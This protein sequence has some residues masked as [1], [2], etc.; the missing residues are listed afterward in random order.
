VVGRGQPLG[1]F[2]FVSFAWSWAV[3]FPLALASRGLFPALPPV[4]HLLIAFGPL[5]GGVAASARHDGGWPAARAFLGR[6]WKGGRGR[7][8]AAGAL[9]P[10]ALFLAGGALAVS[11]RASRAV[12]E[13]GGS[14]W[15]GPSAVVA[16]AAYTLTFGIGEETGWRGFLLPRLAARHGPVG[17]TLRLFAV[18]AGWHLPLLLDRGA[19][20]AGGAFGF[21]QFFA[22]LFAGAFVQTW[23]ASRASPSIW[24]CA[25][26]HGTI[27]GCAAF[28]DDAL[29]G[30][31]VAAFLC[32]GAI[33]LL[34]RAPQALAP[35]QPRPSGMGEG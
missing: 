27:N 35:L 34:L 10:V 18:W 24:P 11:L 30:G 5:L 14:T 7:W 13:G 8:L 19:I 20:G 29:V 28:V 16:S 23:L 26:L 33:V 25:I 12:P 4:L 22:G 3:G 21:A 2:V 15:I 9:I 32:L 6:C 17:G 1:T 31:L